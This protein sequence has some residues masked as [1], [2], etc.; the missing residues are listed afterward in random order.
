MLQSGRRDKLIQRN[1]RRYRNRGKYTK[2]T[3]CADCGRALR[4]G[5]LSWGKAPAGAARAVC[6][7]LPPDR[8]SFPRRAVELSG[9][10]YRDHRDEILNLVRNRRGRR[11][12]ER[13]IG[14]DHGIAD[15][16]GGRS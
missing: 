7:A 12:G 1:A 16:A 2:P 4:G 5:A 11:E 3:V 13:P 15:E 10:F 6:P 14:A 9:D 8:R